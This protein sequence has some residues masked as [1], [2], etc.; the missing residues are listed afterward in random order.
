MRLAQAAVRLLLRAVL[1][2]DEGEMVA[3]VRAALFLLPIDHAEGAEVRVRD[4]VAVVRARAV[5][6]GHAAGIGIDRLLGLVDR[7]VRVVD[8]VRRISDRAEAVKS[9]LRKLL[10]RQARRAGNRDVG[11][12]VVEVDLPREGVGAAGEEVA[13][14][15]PESSKVH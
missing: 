8:G 14:I 10:A 13:V 2:A 5:A 6:P 12:I 4:P 1:K 3:V 11:V 15:Q 9:Q 7:G